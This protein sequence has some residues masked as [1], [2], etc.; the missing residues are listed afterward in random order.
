VLNTPRRSLVNLSNDRRRRR[1]NRRVERGSTLMPDSS[2]P[3][4]L[5]VQASHGQALPKSGGTVPTARPG[6]R[7]DSPLARVPLRLLGLFLLIV[8][9]TIPSCQALFPLDGPDEQPFRPGFVRD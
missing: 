6:A 1:L 7:G 8:A 5:P 9:I 2:F 4:P 3:P